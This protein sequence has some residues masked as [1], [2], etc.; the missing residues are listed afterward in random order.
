MSYRI[1]STIL[2][3]AAIGAAGAGGYYAGQ[4]GLRWP[5]VTISTA[6]ATQAPAAASGPIVYYRDPDGKPSYSAGPR[7]TAAGHDYLPVH[8]DED[9]SFDEASGEAV[10]PAATTA[11][12]ASPAGAKRILYYRNPMG[13][14]DTSQAP[15]KDSM[16]MDYIPV[17]EGDSDDGDAVKVSP[18][19][20]QRTGV[21]T[22]TAQSRIL[23]LP[24][25]AS[26]TIQL[27]ERRISVVATRSDAFIDHV[28]DV[29]TGDRVSKGQPLLRLY[30]P[31]IAAASAQYL[32]SLGAQGSRQRLENLNVPAEVIDE[33]ERNRKAATSIVWTAPRNGIVTE[34]NVVEGMKAAPGDVLFRLADIST[35][36]ALIDVTE[37]DLPMIAVGQ[38]V[39]VRARGFV[40]SSFAGRVTV[41][42]PQVNKETRTTRVRVELAN[43]DG[44]LRPDMY[45]DAEIATGSQAPVTTV[46]MSAVIDSGTRQVVIV[47]KGEGRFEPRTVTLGQRNSDFA[48]IKDGVAPGDKVVVAAN[49]LIDAESNLK[50]AL[51]GLATSGDGK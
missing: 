6:Q 26:G 21:R 45:V 22:E 16:G 30:S 15:K 51:Q 31:D 9:I 41:I 1:A 23:S 43:P 34:R 48:E 14:P 39:T 24:V 5:G 46:P 38:T 42:Y 33:I 7:K 49:F 29:T 18:G 13:L 12:A 35:V 20:L 11:K 25:R 47:D 10:S 3:F 40:D 27:D 8:A 19:K 32:S 28:E 37:R 36:W 50:A 2:T 4:D 44:I 17:F